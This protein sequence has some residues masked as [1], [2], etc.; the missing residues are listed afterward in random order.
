ML[1]NLSADKK[2]CIGQEA[3][4]ILNVDDIFVFLV[5]CELGGTFKNQTVGYNTPC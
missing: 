4:I 1:I 5:L 2:K 3:W